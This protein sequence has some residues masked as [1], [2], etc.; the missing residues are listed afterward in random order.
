L[1]Q[2][3]FTLLEVLVAFAIT[4]TVCTAVFGAIGTSLQ[5]HARAERIMRASLLAESV[6]A[7]VVAAGDAGARMGTADDCTWRSEPRAWSAP[8]AI[9]L[10]QGVGLTEWRVEITCGN[11]ARP[12]T[13]LTTLTPA[14]AS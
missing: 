5:L 9:R 12:L 13:T 1:R 11:D 6:M 3:G 4:A 7:E 2:R 14:V 10:Q 8:A